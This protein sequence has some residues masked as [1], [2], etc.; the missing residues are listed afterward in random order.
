M[1]IFNSSP[2]A[3][4][5]GPGQLFLQLGPQRSVEVRRRLVEQVDRR[6]AGQRPGQ[7]DALLLAAGQLGRPTIGQVADVHLLE[8]ATG[9]AAR[10]CA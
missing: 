2:T 10:F 5:G 8:V 1:P 9:L 6:P 4:S 7:P 3:W